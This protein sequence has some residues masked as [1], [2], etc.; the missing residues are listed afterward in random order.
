VNCSTTLEE[1]E[2]RVFQSVKEL[3]TETRV[4]SHRYPDIHTNCLTAGE[5]SVMTDARLV[6]EDALY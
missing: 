4:G 2:S 6:P 3:E 1:F 5:A